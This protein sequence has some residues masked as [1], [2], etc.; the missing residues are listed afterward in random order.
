MKDYG[1]IARPLI[2]LLKKGNFIQSNLDRT[3]MAKLK[4]L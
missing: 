3:T 2:D 1:K 4:G